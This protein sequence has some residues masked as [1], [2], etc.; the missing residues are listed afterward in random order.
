MGTALR[1]Q[2]DL[3]Q[4]YQSRYLVEMAIMEANIYKPWTIE[5]EPFGDPG[6]I[7]WL[8]RDSRGTV[9]ALVDTEADAVYICSRV[10]MI[11]EYDQWKPWNP[12]N[13]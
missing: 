5:A 10:N 11:Q 1:R 2:R 3:V 4:S 9:I 8:I 12:T 7:T 6:N 13:S